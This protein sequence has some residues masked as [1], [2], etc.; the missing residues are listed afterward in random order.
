MTATPLVLPFDAVSAADLPHVGGKGANLGEMTRAGFPVPPGFCITTAAFRQFMNAC[1]DVEVLYAALATLGAEDVVAARRVGQE[2]RQRLQAVAIP[3]EVMAAVTAAWAEA[4]SQYSY[5]VRSS[6][7]AEDLPGTSFAGQQDTFLNVYGRDALLENIRLCW[8]S[9]FTDRAILYRIQNG[10]SHRD[11]YL[12]VVVQRMVM[13]EVSGILFTADPITGHRHIVSIDASYG[14]GEALVAGLVSAD[15]YQVDKRSDA[16]VTVR[17][18]D[19]HLAIRPQEGGGT[20]REELTGEQ[21]TAR[22]LTERQ[23]VELA[24]MGAE[25]EA[26]YGRPQ[27]IEWCLEDG[28]VYIVQSRPITALYP[29]VEPRPDDG[30]LH[31]YVSFGHAQVMTDPLPPMAQSIWR[32]LFPPGKVAG[33][34]SD[35]ASLCSAGGRLYIDLTPLMRIGFLRRRLP[36]F[37]NIVDRL[38]AQSVGEVVARDEFRAG[39][40]QARPVARIRAILAFM[41]PV[42]VRIFLNLWWRS[43]ERVFNQLTARIDD[44]V[45][46]V[47]DE[48][49]AAEP[50][51]ARLKAARKTLSETMIDLVSHFPPLIATGML[52]QKLVNHLTEGV[53]EPQALNAL[54]RGLTGN[55]TTEMDLA[56]GD[57]ADLARQSPP[58]V[59][60]LTGMD[61]RRALDTLLDGSVKIS[62]SE[63]F[64]QGWQQFI[65]RYGMRGLS[66]IDISRP[67]WRDDPSSVIQAIAGNLHHVE[68]GSHRDHHRRLAA[69]GESV[70]RSLVE[71]ARHG[72]LGFIRARLVARQVAVARTLLAGREHP[73][74]CIIRIAGMVREAILETAVILQQQN[75]IDMVSDVWFLDLHELIAAVEQPEMELRPRIARRRADHGRYQQMDPPR[76]LTSDG[77]SPIVKPVDQEIPPGALGGSPASAGTV[78]GRARVILDPASEMLLKGEILVA[79]FTDPGWTPLFI[80]AAGL[81]MEVGGLMTHGSVVAR[82]YGIPAVVSVPQATTRIKTGQRVRIHGDLGYVEILADEVGQ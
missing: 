38:L 37:L 29:L 20:Y 4:G 1:D 22:V 40:A 42:A 61:A 15:L 17:V 44:Y 68:P 36:G 28:R 3:G 77:E 16:I 30:A 62:D 75:R 69:D 13:P 24:Q 55:V 71:A 46:A 2:V 48:L 18:A 67:R 51:A 11:V 59:A 52:S 54:A 50:G 58:L 39:V 9:L 80:N 6:A 82:E 5:A 21:R 27:D 63:P 7:T 76:V 57:L 64:V 56:V 19:K 34:T 35:S 45:I 78:E 66:E 32:V 25:I 8:I 43:P 33:P 49:A 41:L 53:A 12:S 72:P 47:R 14:L 65:D 73:K 74:F 10:F 26:H 79:P 70:A 31:L 81:I 60:H 23:V